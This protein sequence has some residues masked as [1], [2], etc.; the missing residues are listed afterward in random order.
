MTSTFPQRV[1]SGVNTLPP[2]GNGLRVA[3]LNY[4]ALA[5]TPP[6]RKSVFIADKVTG[7]A[8]ENVQVSGL[9]RLGAA[10][11]CPPAVRARIDRTGYTLAVPGVDRHISRSPENDPAGLIECVTNGHTG[12]GRRGS[13]GW[14]R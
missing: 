10:D 8:I 14:S 12:A 4:R 11:K 6:N 13:P 1:S 9:A 3:V 7:R 5:T 2:E